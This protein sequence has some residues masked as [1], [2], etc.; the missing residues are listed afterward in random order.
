MTTIEEVERRTRHQR[1]MLVTAMERLFSGNPKIAKPGKISMVALAKEAAVPLN[2]LNRYHTEL[3]DEFR[4]K[5]EAMERNAHAPQTGREAQLMQRVGELESQVE[6]LARKS[7]NHQESSR[8]W[9]RAFRAMARAVHARE[10][11][12]ASLQTM[13]RTAEHTRTVLQNRIHDLTHAEE[14]QPSHAPQ[15][16]RSHIR[17]VE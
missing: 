14:N 15:T 11:E 16:A 10:A 8:E 4:Q 12:L 17:P 5:L 3:A 2:H 13:L 7:R 1:R 6:E 9:E